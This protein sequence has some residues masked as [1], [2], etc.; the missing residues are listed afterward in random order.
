MPRYASNIQI[1][2]LG[3]AVSLNGTE[4]VEI[5]QSGESK[6]ATTQQIADLQGVGPTGP[7]GITGPTGPTG[8]SVT[9]PTGSTGPAGPTGPTGNTGTTG[10]TGPTGATP[11]IGGSSTQVQ[12]NSSGAF[13]GSAN[14]T[15][16]GTT[17][18][19][20]SATLSTGNLTFSGTAQRIT[21]DFSNATASSRLMFQSSTVNGATRFGFIPNGTST[22]CIVETFNSSDPNNASNMRLLCLA[23]EARLETTKTGTGTLVP[24][25]FYTSGTEAMR[26][27][28]SGNIGIGTATPVSKLQVEGDISSSTNAYIYSYAGSPTPQVRSGFQ[29]DGTN[30]QTLFFTATA[31]RMRIDSSGNVGIGTSSPAIKL[32]VTGTTLNSGI[33]VTN[34]T[35]ALNIGIVSNYATWQGSG[36]SD[37]F[38][39]AGFGARNLILGTNGAE[40]MRITSAGDVGIGATPNAS[41]ILDAQSTTKGVRFPNMTTTEKNAVSSPAA[42]LVVFD[43]TLAKLCVYSGS[44]WQTITSV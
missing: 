27:D 30:Q 34:S 31:E 42:G 8:P 36:T 21:G 11:A 44:A 12:Y 40:R 16:D 29:L 37:D 23:T 18:T 32:Q 2:N 9:G 39:I 10:P 14:L 22:T 7:M 24:M 25:T 38:V 4:Q 43:T 41:A 1:P 13:A 15:F 19:A 3:A 26:I 17:L 5:V 28:S 35:S 20:N 33:I 6:R